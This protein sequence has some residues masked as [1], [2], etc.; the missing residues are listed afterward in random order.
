[1]DNEILTV[2][3]QLDLI[4]RFRIA[5]EKKYKLR[6][7]K[8]FVENNEKGYIVYG[9]E[10]NGK[11]PEEITNVCDPSHMSRGFFMDCVIGPIGY[12]F[13]KV[14]DYKVRCFLDNGRFYDGDRY[15]D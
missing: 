5:V 13:G 10:K 6:Y 3:K 11:E 14:P 2:R 1:M 9:Y 7:P 12:F 8:V 15:K 4:D